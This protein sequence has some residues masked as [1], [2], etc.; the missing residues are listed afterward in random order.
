[1][2]DLAKRTHLMKKSTN[3]IE[4]HSARFGKV[5]NLAAAMEEQSSNSGKVGNRG[6][7]WQRK[8]RHIKGLGKSIYFQQPSEMKRAI[9]E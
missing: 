8:R 7:I 5:R 6:G 3:E 1:M 4:H 9:V 2:F